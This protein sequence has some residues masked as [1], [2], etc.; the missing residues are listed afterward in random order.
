MATVAFSIGTNGEFDQ[1]NG[2]PPTCL[3]AV[4]LEPKARLNLF[5]GI[6]HYYEYPICWESAEVACRSV[7][8]RGLRQHASWHA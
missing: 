6:Y 2:M 7:Q 8:E 3:H 4:S 1:V 5:D